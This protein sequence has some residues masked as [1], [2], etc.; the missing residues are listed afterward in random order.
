MTPNVRPQEGPHGGAPVAE[1]GVPDRGGLYQTPWALR[2]VL[3]GRRTRTTAS[4][5]GER[6]FAIYLIDVYGNKE[7]IHRDLLLFAAHSRSR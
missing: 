6:T 4:P 2:S 7:L 1:G 3:P 5:G